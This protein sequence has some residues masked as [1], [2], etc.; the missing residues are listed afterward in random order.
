MPTSDRL[1]AAIEGCKVPCWQAGYEPGELHVL[2]AVCQCHGKAIP[3]AVAE[4]LAAVI[5]AAVEIVE[6]SD[7]GSRWVSSSEFR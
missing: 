4:L 6:N 3:P 2:C 5:E 1:R 7:P